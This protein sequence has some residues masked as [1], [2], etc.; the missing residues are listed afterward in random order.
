MNEIVVSV[1][2][3]A[4]PMITKAGVSVETCFAPDLPLVSVDVSALSQAIQ[5][6]IQNA[7][8][9]SGESRWLAIRTE[10]IE[11]K[12]GAEVQVVVEDRGIGIGQDDLPHI[13]EPFYRSRAANAAQIHGTGLGLF[14]AREAV[15]SMGGRIAAESSPGKRTA[16]AIQLPALQP[17]AADSCSSPG[18]GTS[19][20]AL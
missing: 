4:K 13:F 15:A 10:K 9:Y 17:E 2:E 12:R 5:N 18:E 8:K 1:L 7:V 19:S 3:Q 11:S 16:F 14:M 20:N 6:L